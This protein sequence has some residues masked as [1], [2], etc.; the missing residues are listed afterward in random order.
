MLARRGRKKK[1]VAEEE[2]PKK[3]APKA[4]PKPAPKA[5]VRGA[6][7]GTNKKLPIGQSDAPP[8]GAR[9]GTNKKLPQ[10]TMTAD[11]VAR[12]GGRA[13][14][15]RSRPAGGTYGTPGGKVGPRK[16]AFYEKAGSGSGQSGKQALKRPA[17]KPRPKRKEEADVVKRKRGYSGGGSVRGVG[18]AKRGFGRGKIV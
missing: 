16:P 14:Q 7:G 9:G 8:R 18:A 6:Q 10:G 5:A 13:S 4:A 15:Q 3:A 2:E 17:A 1:V 11:E 12:P